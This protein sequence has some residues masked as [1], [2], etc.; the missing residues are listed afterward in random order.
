LE[1]QKKPLLRVPVLTTEVPE[2]TVAG[3]EVIFDPKISRELAQGTL[4]LVANPQAPPEPKNRCRKQWQ[5]NSLQQ[6]SSI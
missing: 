6:G 3:V 4:I 5:N 2:G 1:T